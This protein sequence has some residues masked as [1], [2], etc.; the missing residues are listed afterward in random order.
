[1]TVLLSFPSNGQ[2]N[3]EAAASLARLTDQLCCDVVSDESIVFVRSPLCSL[4]AAAVSVMHLTINV[5]TPV[6]G[7]SDRRHEV[8]SPLVTA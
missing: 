7:N 5:W 2:I 3:V 1:V 6:Y 4:A 8:R